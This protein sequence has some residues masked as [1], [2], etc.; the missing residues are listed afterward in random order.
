MIPRLSRLFEPQQNLQEEKTT[1]MQKLS[2]WDE[3]N[4][5]KCDTRGLIFKCT[6]AA[7]SL[8]IQC[9][10]LAWSFLIRWIGCRS[11]TEPRSQ[12]IKYH[13]TEKKR[14]KI[15]CARKSEISLLFC[16]FNTR[17]NSVWI[18][19]LHHYCKPR[20]YS[21]PRGGFIFF[22]IKMFYF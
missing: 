7:K 14:R 5:N 3:N 21:R 16:R 8:G 19:W 4:K 13:R 12:I 9:T 6:R 22:L 20:F 2:G 1:K 11:S 10:Q 15:K 18:L 17:V